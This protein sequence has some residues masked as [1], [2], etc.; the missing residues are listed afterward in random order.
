MIRS[1]PWFVV[2][3]AGAGSVAAF[4][5]L[6]LIIGP[7]LPADRLLQFSAVVLAAGLLADVSRVARARFTV[8]PNDLPLFVAGPPVYFALIALL[9]GWSLGGEFLADD[10]F[11]CT[12]GVVSGWE[13]YRPQPGWHHFFPLGIDLNAV[14][15]YIDGWNPFWFH[16]H[17]LIVW[18]VTAVAVMVLARQWT[19]A[20]LPAFLAGLLWLTYPLHLEGVLWI[21]IT[22][23]TYSTLFAVVALLAFTWYIRDGV[24]T[25]VVLCCL[26]A[27]ASMLCMEQGAALVPA[28]WVAAWLRRDR[29][30]GRRPL[31]LLAALAAPALVVGGLLL[32]KRLAAGQFAYEGVVQAQWLHSACA[33]GLSLLTPGSSAGLDVGLALAHRGTPFAAAGFVLALGLTGWWYWATDQPAVRFGLALVWLAG[34]PI[35]VGSPSISSRHYLL[36]AVGIALALGTW[37]AERPAPRLPVVL[38]VA[39]AG[40]LW[41]AGWSQDFAAAYRA[42]AAVRAGIREHVPPETP[43]ADIAFV[44][45]PWGVGQREWPVLTFATG[46][47]VLTGWER[48]DYDLDAV[49]AVRVWRTG[50]A[51]RTASEAEPVDQATLAAAVADPQQIVLQWD[52]HAQRLSRLGRAP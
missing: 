16:L 49:R 9:Y 38:I 12:F 43:Y 50:R 7:W 11:N 28:C 51:G 30:E 22:A 21:C 1:R 39:A 8:D 31:A 26:A 17:Q 10:F 13:L 41:I 42:S 27:A 40:V 33:Y 25:G 36:P 19:R 32:W 14:P 2:T 4:A 52:A 23:Y 34:L 44:D 24:W 20:P 48:G 45:L 15:Y 46:V 35:I 3:C 5:L 6:R 18:W 29:L 37:A 47:R